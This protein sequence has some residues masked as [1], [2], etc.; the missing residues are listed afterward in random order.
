MERG[1]NSEVS[2]WGAAAVARASRGR[3]FRG[4]EDRGAGE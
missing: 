4:D 1:G 3:D 2:G